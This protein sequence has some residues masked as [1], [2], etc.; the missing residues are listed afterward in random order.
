MDKPLET[1]SRLLV[2]QAELGRYGVGMYVGAVTAKGYVFSFR[3]D[4]MC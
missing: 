3:G 2:D 4:D 1:E